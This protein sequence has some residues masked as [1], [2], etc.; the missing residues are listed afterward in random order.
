MRKILTFLFYIMS[1]ITAAAQ[2]NAYTGIVI[3]NAGD[4]IHGHID[5]RSDVSLSHSCSFKADGAEKYTTFTPDSI[6]AFRFDD[7][8]KYYVSIY[9]PLEGVMQQ[10]FAEFLIDGV[11]NLYYV[12]R[13]KDDYYF[14]ERED[15]ELCPIKINRREG[16]ADEQTQRFEMRQRG[17]LRDFLKKSPTAVE[18]VDDRTLTHQKAIEAVKGYHN[19][20]CTDNSACITYEYKKKAEYRRFR[21]KIVAGYDFYNSKMYECFPRYHKPDVVNDKDAYCHSFEAGVGVDLS[22]EREVPGLMLQAAL[23]YSPY[24]S[25]KYA[26]HNDKLTFVCKSHFIIYSLGAQYAFGHAR[27]RPVIR[28]G[29]TN[30]EIA[31]AYN[32]TNNGTLDYIISQKN[33]LVTFGLVEWSRKVG[34]YV[35]A[36][37][38][39]RFGKHDVALHADYTPRHIGVTTE[40]IF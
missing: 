26:A 23:T 37:C 7:N 29:I 2:H 36:G 31:F 17:V 9:L 27:V 24:K 1:S 35:G 3:S 18:Q 33:D 8:G 12:S 14:F 4:T 22:L 16:V 11:M 25:Q 30:E 40:F 10:C 20:V 13:V 34:Y 6:R 5:L 28:G 15:G 19:D 32:R 21:F 39:I 38:N